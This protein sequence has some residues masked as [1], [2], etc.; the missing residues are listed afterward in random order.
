LGAAEFSPGAQFISRIKSVRPGAGRQAVLKD[1][2]P[3]HSLRQILK[4]YRK[5]APKKKN[6]SGRTVIDFFTAHPSAS[7][8]LQECSNFDVAPVQFRVGEIELVERGQSLIESH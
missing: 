7:D 1:E 2:R 3:G 5:F 4:K 8:H 6:R